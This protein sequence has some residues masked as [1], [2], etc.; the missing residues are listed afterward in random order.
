[1]SKDCD[2]WKLLERA[3]YFKSQQSVDS[4]KK[5]NL[6]KLLQLIGKLELQV[7]ITLGNALK[8]FVIQLLIDPV[9]A[10]D[11]LGFWSLSGM[12]LTGK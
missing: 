9:L 10:V 11:F 2:N 5:K 8:E 12:F 4:D 1:M 7:E 6:K 3:S